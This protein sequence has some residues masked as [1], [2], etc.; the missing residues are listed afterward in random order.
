M[1]ATLA[2]GAGRPLSDEEDCCMERA[3]VFADYLGPLGS[4]PQ[5][6]TQGKSMTGAELHPLHSAT[7]SF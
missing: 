2:Y 6:K 4:V 7:K 5:G 3:P 1:T